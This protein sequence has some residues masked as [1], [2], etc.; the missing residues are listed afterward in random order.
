LGFRRHP[1]S[2]ELMSCEEI[3]FWITYLLPTWGISLLNRT[4]AFKGQNVCRHKADG[5]QRIYPTEQVRC[6]H[7]LRRIIAGELLPV[8]GSVGPHSRSAKGYTVTPEHPVPIRRLPKLRYDLK[9]GRLK[10]EPEPPPLPKLPSFKKLLENPPRS[11][12]YAGDE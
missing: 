10:I 1:S 7:V 2:D 9:T 5:R 12:W 8:R 3:G 4:L 11:I 6:S